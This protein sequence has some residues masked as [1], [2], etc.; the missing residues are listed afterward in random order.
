[1]GIFAQLALYIPYSYLPQL[2]MTAGLDDISASTLISIMS[3]SN[4]VGRISCGIVIDR[5]HINCRGHQAIMASEIFKMSRM[6][7]F[8]KHQKIKFSPWPK[9]P[10]NISLQWRGRRQSTRDPHW[11]WGVGFTGGRKAHPS[12]FIILGRDYP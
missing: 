8:F 4:M 3:L 12:P 6:K 1:M 7:G 2:A 10:A 9:T 5:F 11:G